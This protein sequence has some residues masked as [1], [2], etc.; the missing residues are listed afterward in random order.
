MTTT[1]TT[2]TTS[3]PVPAGGAAPAD[4]EAWRARRTEVLSDPHGW[5]SLTALH[6]LGRTP[7]R[8][9][10]VPGQ[11]WAGADGVHV[12]AGAGDGL[13][14]DGEPLTDERV[15]HPVDDGAGVTVVAGERHVEVLLRSGNAG[16][17][18]RDP[19][20]PVLAAFTGVPVFAFDGRW[21]LDGRLEAEEDEVVVGSVVAGLTQARTAAGRV[22]FTTPDGVERSLLALRSGDGLQLL[23]TD[24]TTGVSSSPTARSMTVPAPGPDGRVVVDLNRAQNLPCAFTD[25]ATC[26]LPPAGNRLD[27]AVEAGERAPR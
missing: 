14:L 6:W 17:R 23:F 21:V 22:R 15:L 27:V 2:S 4:W 11:W 9:G 5:L 7:A 19:R 26:P 20:S 25:H 13:V 10:D 12:R 24:L 3:T 16:L 8:A 18:V 1:S